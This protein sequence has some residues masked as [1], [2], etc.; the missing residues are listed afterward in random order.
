MQALGTPTTLAMGG[1]SR[2]A[3][4]SFR[5]RWSRI[6]L[7]VGQIGPAGHLPG[8]VTG[9]DWLRGCRKGSIRARC[10]ALYVRFVAVAGMVALAMRAASQCGALPV[11]SNPSSVRREAPLWLS[12]YVSTFKLRRA[13]S[14]GARFRL[15]MVP[16]A[17]DALPVASRRSRIAPFPDYLGHSNGPGTAGF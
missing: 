3:A 15:S 6:P 11:A 5:R 7:P 14:A 8:A 4:L 10:G 2:G 1:K 17:Q 16:V 13:V 12:C 9:C